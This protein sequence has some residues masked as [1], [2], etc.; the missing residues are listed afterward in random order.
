MHACEIVEQETG[1]ED[2]S[3]VLYMSSYSPEL[4]PIENIFEEY[5]KGLRRHSMNMPWHI[6]YLTAMNLVMPKMAKAHDMMIK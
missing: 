1:R 2:I 3:K 4:N 6:A 5:T